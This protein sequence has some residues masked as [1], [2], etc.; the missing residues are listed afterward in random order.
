MVLL[1]KIGSG[2]VV[3]FLNNRTQKIPGIPFNRCVRNKI[4]QMISILGQ[5]NIIGIEPK[6]P[7]LQSF[8]EFH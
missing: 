6:N 7:K 2:K 8:L 5:T 4:S 3:R 1:L